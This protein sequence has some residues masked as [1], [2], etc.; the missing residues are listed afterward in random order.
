AERHAMP[1]AGH[2][3]CLSTQAKLADGREGMLAMSANQVEQISKRNVRPVGAVPALGAH[4]V[5]RLLDLEQIDERLRL[6][7]RSVQTGGAR[8][9]IVHA[10][11]HRARRAFPGG[12]G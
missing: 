2:E 8:N 7:A 12:G 9:G 6:L 4:L 1:T 3:S 5:Q 10:E 11:K